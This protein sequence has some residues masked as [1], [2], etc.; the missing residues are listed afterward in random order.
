MDR[1]MGG[2]VV[3][4]HP[5]HGSSTTGAQLGGSG[6]PRFTSSSHCSLPAQR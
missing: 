4:P 5:E 3:G 6:S 2:W 1:W